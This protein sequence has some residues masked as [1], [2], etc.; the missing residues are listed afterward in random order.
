MSYKLN[1]TE[2][3]CLCFGKIK[4]DVFMYICLDLYLII[5]LVFDIFL[6]K[7]E[8]ARDDKH[9]FLFLQFKDYLDEG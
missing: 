8:K 7:I 3:E 2:K 6:K 9:V 4:C 5:L 1:L